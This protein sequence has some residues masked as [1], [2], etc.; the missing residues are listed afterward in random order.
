MDWDDIF[1]A[2]AA[3]D[4]MVELQT[5]ASKKGRKRKGGK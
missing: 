1:E 3:L 2:N 4:Y 5:K